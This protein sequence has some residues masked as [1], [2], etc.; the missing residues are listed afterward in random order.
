M[1]RPDPMSGR[2]SL[3]PAGP[4][5]LSAIVAGTSSGYAWWGQ[6]FLA[7]SAPIAQRIE[8]LPPKQ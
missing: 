5:V 3:G 8:Q 1:P 6:K 7:V 4:R 2:L